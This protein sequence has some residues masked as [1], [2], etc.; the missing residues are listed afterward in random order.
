[1]QHY[2]RSWP[3]RPPPYLCFYA[4]TPCRKYAEAESA[5]RTQTEGGR[6]Q[7]SLFQSP[8]RGLALG[9]RSCA[10]SWARTELLIV[11]CETLR[12]GGGR[13]VFQLAFA[14]AQRRA[15]KAVSTFRCGLVL[16]SKGSTQAPAPRDYP[17]SLC[18]VVRGARAG[19]PGRCLCGGDKPAMPGAPPLAASAATGWKRATGKRALH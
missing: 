9:A 15:G 16:C 7:R 19:R 6:P 14:G 10:R 4:A 17:A 2:R 1:M 12:A 5:E 3:K 8:P 13:W 18:R 11:S